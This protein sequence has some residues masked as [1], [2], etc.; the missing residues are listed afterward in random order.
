MHLPTGTDTTTKAAGRST[1][2]T[3]NREK[4]FVEI[5]CIRNMMD[6]LIYAGRS[7]SS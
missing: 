3:G 2:W 1:K 4:A 5:I 7:I 6:V